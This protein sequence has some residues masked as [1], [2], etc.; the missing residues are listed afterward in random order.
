MRNHQR[1]YAKA[2]RTRA[3][4]CAR[5]KLLWALSGQTVGLAVGSEGGPWAGAGSAQQSM[6]VRVRWGQRRNN[7]AFSRC[8]VGTASTCATD[9]TAVRLFRPDEGRWRV[10]R[11][12]CICGIGIAWLVLPC[13]I[14]SEPGVASVDEGVACAWPFSAKLTATYR[15]P[16]PR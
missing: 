4:R 3:P 8:G 15:Q 12:G 11:K 14:G 2:S 6:P 5:K 1:R 16:Q 13:G 9:P 10:E 7:R